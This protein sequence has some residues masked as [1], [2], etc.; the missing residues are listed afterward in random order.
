MV[1]QLQQCI[2]LESTLKLLNKASEFFYR[3]ERKGLHK[4]RKV[5]IQSFANF[6]FLQNL[7]KKTFVNFAVKL[8][9]TFLKPET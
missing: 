8:Y 1:Q 2:L 4:V 9:S 3:K 7:K 5:F 6:I